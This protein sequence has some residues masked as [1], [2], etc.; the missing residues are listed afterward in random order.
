MDLNTTTFRIVQALTEEK[1]E[2]A[3]K[4]RESRANAGK[5]GGRQRANALSGERRKEIALGAARARWSGRP[6]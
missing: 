6:R 3:E 4:R 5:R 1:D 2:T